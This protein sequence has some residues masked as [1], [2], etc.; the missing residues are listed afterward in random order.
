MTGALIR[1][2]LDAG[3]DLDPDDVA[4][5]LWLVAAREAEVGQR[6]GPRRAA[7]SPTPQEPPSS[8]DEGDAATPPDASPDQSR[9]IPLRL[10]LAAPRTRNMGATGVPVSVRGAPPL[11]GALHIGRALRPF[12]RVYSSGPGT[13]VDIGATVRATADARRIDPASLVVVS[14]PRLRRKLDAVLVVDAAPSMAVWDDTA[15]EFQ[16]L[17]E[18][19][20]SFRE[21]S[22]WSMTTE[23][24]GTA[25]RCVVR[26]S[27]GG[28]TQPARRIVDR[29]GRRVVFIITDAVEST[30]Y[31]GTRWW[32]V[33]LWARSM[34]TAIVQVLPRRYWAA[35]GIGDLPLAV[36]APSPACPNRLL[37]AERQWWSPH[38]EDAGRGAAV[39]VP[40]I[41][42]TDQALRTWADAVLTGTARVDATF[43]VPPPSGPAQQKSGRRLSAEERIR[44]F[45]VRAS[46]GAHRLAR[47]LSAAPVLSLPL[48]RVLQ[49]R[50]V[51]GTGVTELAEIFV[52]GLLEEIGPGARG[53]A[54]RLYFRPDVAAVL[55]RGS[56]VLE[57]W[58]IFA[59]VSDYLARPHPIRRNLH[60]LAEAP[61][62]QTGLDPDEQPFGQV[63]HRLGQRLGLDST[64]PD[65]YGPTS[66]TRRPG[67]GGDRPR[68]QSRAEFPAQDGFAD[69]FI[70][71]APVDQEWAE[72]IAWE[73]ERDGRKVLVQAWEKPRNSGWVTSLHQGISRSS[74][75]IVVYDERHARAVFAAAGWN[76]AEGE[77]LAGPGRQIVVV[78]VAD[79]PL[80]TSLGPFPAVDLFG[81]NVTAADARTRL[82]D[83]L[84]RILP[85][86]DDDGNEPVPLPPVSEWRAV[87]KAAPFPGRRVP[88]VW[89]NVPP[90]NSHF[91]GREELL[92]ELNYRLRDGFTTV[93]PNVLHGMGGVGKSQ[94]A[95]EYV[96]QHLSDFDVVW[97]IQAERTVQIGQA[98]VELGAQ[99]GLDVGPEASV[100]IRR[101]MRTLSIGKPY[102]RWL[103][104]FDN[105]NDPGDVQEYIP[106][107]PRG[108]VLVTTRNSRWTEIS[109]AI[110]VDVFRREESVD[111]LRGRGGP[112]TDAEADALAE[113][114]GDLPLAIEQAATW[115]AETGMSAQ[116]YLQLLDAKIAEL[117]GT[118]PEDY[119]RPVEAA[120]NVSIDRLRESDRKAFE[121]LG[122]CAFLAPEP[123]S[124][125][126]LSRARNETI[127]PMLDEMLRDPALLSQALRNINRYALAR[128]DDRDNSITM[129]RLIQAA[130]VGRMTPEEQQARR[131][132]A[133]VLLAASDPNDPVALGSWATYADLYPHVMASRAPVS[134]D[135]RVRQLLL[136]EVE[137][138]WWRG[139]YRTSC[140]LSRDVRAAWQAT[141]GEDDGYTL[142][143]TLWHGRSL[144]AIGE[145]T[146]ATEVNL[147]A[148]GVAVGTQGLDSKLAIQLM[149]NISADLRSRG[150]FTKAHEVAVDARQR[151]VRVVAADDPMAMDTAHNVAAALRLL[152]RYA[153]ATEIDEDTWQQ[154]VRL[155]GEDDV[156]SLDVLTRLNIDR[157]ALGDYLGACAR[158]ESL[159][160]QYRRLFEA[161]PNHPARLWS[162]L[163]LAMAL[164]RAGQYEKAL[165]ISRDT[166]ERYSLRYGGEHP[167]ALAAAV[168]LSID[169]R[170]AGFLREA[171]DFCARS[172]D[173]YVLK[174]GEKHPH[175]LVAA[176][177]LAIIERLSGTPEAALIRDRRTLAA[178][179][180][181]LGETHPWALACATNLASDLYSMGEFQEAHDR[182]REV[183]ALLTRMLGEVHPSTLAVAGNIAMDLRALGLHGEAQSLHSATLAALEAAMGPEHHTVRLVA[184]W[185]R[186]DCDVD[187]MPL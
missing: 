13:H 128:I 126:L 23:G 135:R 98:F 91:I 140:D 145:Y 22:Q 79:R 152:G 17:L 11:P 47:V 108:R 39:P 136:N 154:A 173:R 35:S 174:I 67:T 60:A 41:S 21:V 44:A 46:E 14:Q 53:G 50:L 134:A 103:L 160:T 179:V 138:F 127:S 148:Y 19:L 111:L 61:G 163:S 137:Y 151:A 62:G 58:D 143:M 158:Q 7:R 146:E 70:S 56:S 65:S 31:Q 73:L 76:D 25:A 132:G 29:S 117:V 95:I 167:G 68:R 71:Y 92:A 187:P 5:L 176:I 83:L 116:E 48:I 120:W 141:S 113:A 118:S 110:E 114:L 105:A 100:A 27:N 172:L 30:W 45:D 101:V 168:A 74:L 97:W 16:R 12:R 150:D 32:A 139:D 185:V 52:A 84:Y 66:T 40:V 125:Q 87:P 144:H 15:R 55:Q 102:D 161:V 88:R 99:L 109:S 2:L 166:E 9:Y 165:E 93:A 171:H 177:N 33:D 149:G 153:E 78:R 90:R 123:I 96:Y 180:E 112:L 77:E 169:L 104:V 64:S 51:P 18:Q 107:S 38:T 3:L 142:L 159:D 75:T 94:L 10:P 106:D 82:T 181:R 86:A 43:A 63:L 8:R 34:P 182:D 85:I 164:R 81:P 156:R 28:P 124:R 130:L 89:G 115:R 6:S 36:R 133:H 59:A 131:H 170:H 121:L 20:G 49:T 119:R 122:V 183:L 54:R 147:G 42:L 186:T 37:R 4:D 80:P 26:P 1:R 129:H 157:R 69:F 175:T 178:M 184:A 57:E 72:W 162:A 155:Y 24:S